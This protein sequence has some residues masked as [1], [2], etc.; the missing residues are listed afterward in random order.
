MNEFKKL[1]KTLNGMF[2]LFTVIK[3]LIISVSLFFIY[4]LGKLAELW[5]PGNVQQSLNDL[6]TYDTIPGLIFNIATSVM[7][8]FIPFALYMFFSGKKVEEVAMTRKPTL[9]QCACTLG[10]TAMFTYIISYIA[11]IIIQLIMTL[12]GLTLN[13]FSVPVTY[14]VW[15]IPFFII[16]LCVIPGFTEEFLMR[17]IAL[18]NTKKYGIGFAIVISS[19][20]FSMLHNT[21]MQLPYAFAAGLSLAYF[22]I[23]F[24]SIWVAVIAHF[25]LN[26]N[27]VILQICSSLFSKKEEIFFLGVYMIF[28]FFTVLCFTIANIVLYG[29]KLPKQQEESTL[30][31]YKKIGAVFITPYFYTFVLLFIAVVTLNILQMM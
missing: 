9:L 26:L 30:P 31:L 5:A 4:P 20:C 15:L 27:S 23:K 10:S 7:V 24:K 21:I 14:N 19:V 12:F 17:G 11:N 6:N 28:I 16:A 3:L 8:I 18:E 29:F 22:A 1:R 13:G 2:G 25:A